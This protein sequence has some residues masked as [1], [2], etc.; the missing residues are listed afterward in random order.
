MNHDPL[1]AWSER[2]LGP[3]FFGFTTLLLRH[4]GQLGIN[5]LVF[6]ARDGFLLRE[7]VRA[8]LGDAGTTY[9]LQYAHL[10]R[11]STL[12][13]ARPITIS[14]LN[15][16][17]Q[18]RG[19]A[20]TWRSRLAF[21][22]V[23]AADVLSAFKR[24][25]VSLDSAPSD[26]DEERLLNDE[27]LHELLLNHHRASRACLTRYLQQESI[28]FGSPCLLVDVG[29]RGSIARYLMDT[30]AGDASFVPPPVALLG[31]WDEG[32][33]LP[34]LPNGSI[35]LLTDQMRGRNVREGAAWYA[36][37][38]LEAICRGPESPVSGYQLKDGA[39]IATQRP[40]HPAEVDDFRLATPVRAGILSHI[41]KRSRTI[42]QSGDADDSSLDEVQ[43]AL[44]QLAF[45]PDQIA[46]TLGKKLHHTES[47]HPDWACPLVIEQYHPCWRAPRRWL[48]GLKSPW[49]SAY[50]YATGGPALAR[51]FIFGETV[52]L[53][54][55][56][57]LRRWLTATIRA[58]AYR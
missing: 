46:R 48:R 22:G 26:G 30:C 33:P 39:V 1:E 7:A 25:G 58:L 34:A 50:V 4:A 6:L 13:A 19:A 36:G 40:R 43:H 12:L 16:A 38:I 27:L 5:R 42:K 47:H 28:G 31:R 14:H 41:E 49:R 56:Y 35:G 45:F 9:Q 57:V 11:R 24:I 20:V 17:D 21:N 18:V 51:L 3:V 2:T 15:N 32:R 8:R 53:H 10:S 37:L 23:D 52:L 44:F 54:L 29:W 55:P